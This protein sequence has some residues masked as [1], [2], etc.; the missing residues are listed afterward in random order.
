MTPHWDGRA[1]TLGLAGILADAFESAAGLRNTAFDPARLSVKLLSANDASEPSSP[2]H[3][4][5]AG[6]V[7]CP[8]LPLLNL[9]PY[10]ALGSYSRASHCAVSIWPESHFL[11]YVITKILRDCFAVGRREG[12]HLWAWTRLGKFLRL[13][14]LI[15]NCSAITYI[16]EMSIHYVRSTIIVFNLIGKT[17]W[18]LLSDLQR[19]HRRWASCRQS[20]LLWD[21]V[22]ALRESRWSRARSCEANGIEKC[23]SSLHGGA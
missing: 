6:P 18:P 14:V 9:S 5:V 13:A 19:K 10:G 3:G 11:R 2:C 17:S 15:I 23:I 20:G 7:L 12:D 16:T 1:W 22:R 21:A 8:M 4:V